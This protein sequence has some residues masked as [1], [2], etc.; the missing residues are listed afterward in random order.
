VLAHQPEEVIRV[1]R[2]TDY[3]ELGPLEQARETFT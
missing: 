3:V 1:A 2:L